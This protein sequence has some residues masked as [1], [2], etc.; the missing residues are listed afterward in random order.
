MLGSITG[1]LRELILTKD[2]IQPSEYNKEEKDREVEGICKLE[3]IITIDF[4]LE[5]GFRE[6]V[7]RQ[8]KK[9]EM[10]GV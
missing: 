6:E 4:M 9:A 8:G 2:Q 7:K 3:S 5:K 1:V 10:E